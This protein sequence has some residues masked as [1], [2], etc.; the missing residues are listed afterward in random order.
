MDLEMCKE[1]LEYENADPSLY[2]YG[3]AAWVAQWGHQLIAEIEKLR[4][5][6]DEWKSTGF[7]ILEQQEQTLEKAKKIGG[8]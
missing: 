5:D 8:D 3:Y 1:Q 6:I 2:G 7:Y 4:G